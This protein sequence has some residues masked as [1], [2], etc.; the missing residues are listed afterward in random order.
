MLPNP[1]WLVGCGNMAG[2]MVQG[3]K[4]AGADL[5]GATIIRPSGQSVAGIPAVTRFVDA[6]SLP[7]LVLLGFKPQQLGE[8]APQLSGFVTS[9]TTVVSILAGVEAATLRKLFPGAG[10]IV[11]ADPNLP[12]AVRRGVTA[13]YSQDQNEQAREQVS[14]LFS[15]LGYAMWTDAERNLEA[16]G[17]LSGPGP[18]Y[19]ARFVAALAKAGVERGLPK[20]TA[21]TVALET[22]LGTAW[23]AATNQESMESVAQRVASPKG[24]TE[25]GLN[26]LDSDQGLDFL[27]SHALAAAER[28]GAELSEEA[29]GLKLAEK[30]PSA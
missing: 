11:R 17:S 24:T 21:Q 29:R 12:V 28:R 13:L 19:V 22:V 16:I 26:V 23:M 27:V 7:R 4:L 9:R 14:Q 20:A 1:T 5:S 10:T 8:V 15:A 2:S 6:G 3:W 30:A 18:A 25:Q